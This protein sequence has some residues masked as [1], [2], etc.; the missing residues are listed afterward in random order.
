MSELIPNRFELK[1]LIR[2][3]TYEDILRQM[4]NYT[5][6]D[7]NSEEG[8]RYPIVSLY[9]DS[10]DFRFYWEKIQ[11]LPIRQ[12]V[13]IR[14]YGHERPDEAVFLEIKQRYYATVQKYRTKMRLSDAYDA[15]ESAHDRPEKKRSIKGNTI[16]QHAEFLRDLYDLRPQAVISY[17]RHAFVGTFDHRLRITF[18]TCLRVRTEELRLEAGN[19]GRYI[20]PPEFVICEMKVDSKAPEWLFSLIAEHNLEPKRISKYCLGLERGLELQ[21]QLLS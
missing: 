9:Y 10:P 11:G 7:P 3:E 5:S 14:Q 6:A 2:W 20:I 8:G 21:S 1:Y 15:L 12:K 16:L 18:D 4:T 13:R 17:D 19:W